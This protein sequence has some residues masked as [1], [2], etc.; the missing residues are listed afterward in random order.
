MAISFRRDNTW[1]LHLLTLS[2]VLLVF[3][4]IVANGCYLL[5]LPLMGDMLNI[6]SENW[7][8]FFM[9]SICVILSKVPAAITS[10]LQQFI[11]VRNKYKSSMWVTV[12]AEMAGVLFIVVT[13]RSYG[14]M[15]FAAALIVSAMVNAIG[16]LFLIRINVL[17]ALQIRIWKVYYKRLRDT[18]SKIALLGFQTGITHLSLFAERSI[19]F[20]YLSGGYVGAMNYAKSVTELPR[21]VLLSS[22]LTTTYAKQIKLKA[23]DENEYHAYTYKMND[24]IGALA[25]LAQLFSIV[26]APFILIM[27]YQ[28]GAFDDNDIRMTLIIYQILTLGF[29]PGLMFGFLSRIMFIEGENRVMLKW[30]VIKTIVELGL[31]YLLVFQFSQGIPIALTVGKFLIVAMII[32]FLLKRKPGLLDIR[33]FVWRGGAAFIVCVLLLWLNQYLIND[34]LSVDK[35]RLALV[36]I[37]LIGLFGVFSIGVLF[38]TYPEILTFIP[39]LKKIRKLMRMG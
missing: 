27:I 33:K 15:S 9:L 30:I 10:S 2:T 32:S 38:R 24:F 14:V 1:N 29:V 36:Y 20:R 19:A 22:I 21:L 18:F 3:L 5:C 12:F 4:T 34:L 6:R 28:R 26:F 11:Y 17:L 13:A 23:E 37:P 8:V 25:V 16:Y 39:A 7:E 35:W 31:M